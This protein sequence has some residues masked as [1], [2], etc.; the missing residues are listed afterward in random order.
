L[1]VFKTAESGLPQ[2]HFRPECRLVFFRIIIVLTVIASLFF[3]ACPVENYPKNYSNSGKHGDFEWRFY[4]GEMIIEKYTGTGGDVIIPALIDGKRVNRLNYYLFR[5][6]RSITGITIPDGIT[7]IEAGTFYGCSGLTNVLLPDSIT[8]IGD[9]SFIYCVSLTSIKI[10]DNVKSIG[11]GA[12]FSCGLTNIT[13][14]DSLTTIGKQAFYNCDEL[15]NITI[16]GSVSYIGESAFSSCDNLETINVSAD[17]V[18]YSSIDGILYSKDLRTLVAYPN[19]REGVITI[20]DNVTDVAIYAFNTCR[21]L[22][23]IIIP[24][25]V[26][27]IGNYAFEG[28]TNLEAINVNAGNTKYSSRDGILY[29]K[30]IAR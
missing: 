5:D 14:P 28:C 21:K 15:T 29:V 26:T 22:T 11:E 25:S 1:E 7:T 19:N 2:T 24:D 12:F 10:P 8:I 6:C 9:T 4:N 18:S 16:P 17:N 30:I 23:G 27:A 3:T 13:L 20:S